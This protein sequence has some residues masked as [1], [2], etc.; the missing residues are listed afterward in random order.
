MKK[1]K[2]DSNN[3]KTNLDSQLTN[4]K[5]T[6]ITKTDLNAMSSQS[7]GNLVLNHN[8]YRA[9]NEPSNHKSSTNNHNSTQVYQPPNLGLIPPNLLNSV[10]CNDP[11][12]IQSTAVA[13]CLAN[14]I[15]S[16][17]SQQQFPLLPVSFDPNTNPLV[18]L[19]LLN[20]NA[21]FMQQLATFNP[22]LMTPEI[23][24]S[25]LSAVTNCQSNDIAQQLQNQLNNGHPNI[26]PRSRNTPSLYQNGT[27]GANVSTVVSPINNKLQSLSVPLNSS[28]ITTVSND[29]TTDMSE[30]QL[31]LPQGKRNLTSSTTRLT[32]P[33]KKS[34]TLQA[35]SNVFAPKT[36]PMTQE[37]IAEHARLV[38]ERAL[39]RN[40]LRQQSDLMKHVY[41]TLNNKKSNI[42]QPIIKSVTNLSKSN[43]GTT[44]GN[45]EIIKAT[46]LLE[47]NSND[48]FVPGVP[49]SNGGEP[50]NTL[51]SLIKTTEEEIES[52]SN[53][54]ISRY[55]NTTLLLPSTLSD[56]TGRMMKSEDERTISTTIIPHQ[57]ILDP[58]APVFFPRRIVKCSI[59]DGVDNET[60]SSSSDSDYNDFNYLDQFLDE[61]YNSFNECDNHLIILRDN[62]G[63]NDR[64]KKTSTIANSCPINK[65]QRYINN[66]V[67]GQGDA[68]RVDVSNSVDNSTTTTKTC[69]DILNDNTYSNNDRE[70]EN[71]SVVLS[72]SNQ[73]DFCQYSIHQLLDRY[74]NPRCHIVLPEWS[75]LSLILS[76][77]CT[78][79]THTYKIKRYFAYRRRLRENEDFYLTTTIDNGKEKNLKYS[80]SNDNNLNEIT[81]YMNQVILSSQS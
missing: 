1:I 5:N 61:F 16:S 48:L 49:N 9:T 53:Q 73:N 62:G 44:S 17:L 43:L 52:S 67:L 19:Q 20:A 59:G 47:K 6:T 79:R 60:S 3:N 75:R 34:L 27:T 81:S 76:S 24:N 66:S 37:Q 55:D 10:F 8:T 64:G 51:D 71:P 11:L 21:M 31:P 12:I 36:G 57:S 45:H 39:Q 42:A 68:S 41:D 56:N 80:L 29:A 7:F 18:Y 25:L 54:C 32:I 33:P 69:K 46:I 23:K 40:Q 58:A 77:V 35:D 22:L 38:Y 70:E 28:V 2:R 65:S 26:Y 14:K 74:R 72:T 30:N 15:T 78:M 13:A 4:G 63:N 50:G